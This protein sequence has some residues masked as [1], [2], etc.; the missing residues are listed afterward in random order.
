MT[1]QRRSKYDNKKTGGYDSKRESKRAM[2]LSLLQKLGEISELREQVRYELV[3]KQDGE[4]A[5]H[6]TADFVYVE[7]GQTVAEDS[8]GFR[9]QVFI[10]K[11]KLMLFRHGIRIREI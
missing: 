4:R 2:D 1:W 6:Y 8:K 9:T 5:V 11:R 10:I 7:K 3:P